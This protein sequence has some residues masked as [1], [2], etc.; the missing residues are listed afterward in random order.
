MLN[1]GKNICALHDK[2]KK[3]YST[4]RVVRKTNSERNEKP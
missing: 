4:S 1:S 2:K 3:K